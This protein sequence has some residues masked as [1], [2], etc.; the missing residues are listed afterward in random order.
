MLGAQ[1]DVRA[2]KDAQRLKVEADASV[3]ISSIKIVIRPKLV[4]TC[5]RAAGDY[6]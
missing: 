6:R 3:D 1:A 5:S 2:Q 4:L